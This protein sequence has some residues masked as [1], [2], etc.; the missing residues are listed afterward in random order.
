LT[1]ARAGR[2][3]LFQAGQVLLSLRTPHTLAV[4]DVRKRSVIWAAFGPWRIQHDAEFLDNGN[5]F[6]FDNH[7]WNKGCR[8]IE[9]DPVTQAIPWVYSDADADPFYAA[10]RGMKQR[11]P[12]GNTLIVDPDN[13]RLLEVTQDKELVW[14]FFCPMPPVPPNQQPRTR[15]ITSARRYRADELTFLKGVAHARP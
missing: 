15:A 8:V 5:L 14:E 6:L 2:F 3:P 13:R 11:L 7:G 12:N 4:L 10:F 9:Y 1:S